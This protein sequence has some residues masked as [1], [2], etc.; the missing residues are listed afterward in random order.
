MSATRIPLD[1]IANLDFPETWEILRHRITVLN[2]RA[3]ENRLTWPHVVRWL[4]NFD[5]SSGIDS[6][7]ERL[8]ALY[9]LAQFMYFGSR[10]IR[11]LLRATY[12]DLFYSPLVQEVR[13]NLGSSRDLSSIYSAIQAEL[14]ATRFLGVGNPSESG[15]HLLYYFRQ[16][17]GL[18]KDHFLDTAQILKRDGSRGSARVLRYPKVKRYVFVD[19]VCGSGETA[20]RYSSDFLDELLSLN[21][22]A[23]LYYYAL[24]S[25]SEG[26][27]RIRT[28]S[29]F[30]E[31]CGAVY[32]LDE[33]Y[34]ALSKNS[35]YLSITREGIDPEVVRTISNYYGKILCPGHPGGYMNS[36]MLLGFHHNVPDNTLPII[37]KDVSN[38]ATIPWVAAFKRYPKFGG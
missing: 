16:E 13:Q 25:T 38:G 22:D 28:E 30:K 26:M 37:W 17:N 36:Q 7:V 27:T 1:D 4:E 6:Q 15:V 12:R 3:W 5:G 19:D 32:E 20:I 21:P 18:S 24:F 8:H 33:T 10:E 31:N 11:V 14:Q 2:E 29:L 35:R 23:Q 34:K 9:L